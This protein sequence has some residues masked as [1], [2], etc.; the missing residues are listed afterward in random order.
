MEIASSVALSRMIAQQRALDLTA[1]NIANAST[2]GYR[3]QRLQFSDALVRERGQPAGGGTVAYAQAPG[4]WRDPRTG[5]VTHSGNPLDLAIGSN[6]FFTVQTPSG[7]RLTRAGHFE[8]SST[9][10]IVDP[11]GNSLLNDTGQPLQL[12]TSDT[13]LT[14]AGDGTIGSENGQIGKIG[15]V[16]PANEASLRAEGDLLLNTGSPTQQVAAPKITQGAIEE[17]DVQPVVELVRMLDGEKSFQFLSQFIQ[18]EGD[19]QQSAIDKIGRAG[20]NS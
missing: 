14:V 12:S 15:V 17:S 3:A 10:N 8:V 1:A 13:I 7:P 16:A 11:A 6:G 19:R 2:P 20:M 5:P 18:A 4:A 9:G